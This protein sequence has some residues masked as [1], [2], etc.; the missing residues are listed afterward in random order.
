[1]GKGG[2]FG[3]KMKILMKTGTAVIELNLDQELSVVRCQF[4]VE[5]WRTAELYLTHGEVTDTGFFGHSVFC[6]PRGRWN[7][8][9]WGTG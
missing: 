4:L 5:R 2:L 6:P 7:L 3:G 1:M 9:L 8:F